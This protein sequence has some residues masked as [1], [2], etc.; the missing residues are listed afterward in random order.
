MTAKGSGYFGIL[1]NKF[2]G[3]VSSELSA[4]NE[5]GSYPLISPT[6]T[7]AELNGILANKPSDEA[8]SKSRAWQEVQLQKGKDPFAQKLGL[9]FP[10]PT[11]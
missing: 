4:D 2:Q 9:R 7:K 6:L 8:E 3:G 11:E 5:N 1:P 10:Q